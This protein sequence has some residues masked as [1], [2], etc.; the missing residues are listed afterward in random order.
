MPLTLALVSSFKFGPGI[1]RRRTGFPGACQCTRPACP[2]THTRTPWYRFR[3]DC[4]PFFLHS[5]ARRAN[6]WTC[7]RGLVVE[8][9]QSLALAPNKRSIHRH[10][11]HQYEVVQTG[12]VL[13]VMHKYR[14]LEVR[15]RVSPNG[16]TKLFSGIR[17]RRV[18]SFWTLEQAS[19]LAS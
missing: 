11:R 13:L 18:T 10:V 1:R 8:Q 17:R 2:H 14:R 5:C 16:T 4:V 9:S 19:Q 6:V 12:L 3:K 15:V 7:R